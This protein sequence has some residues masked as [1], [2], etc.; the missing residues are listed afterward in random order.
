MRRV[1]CLRLGHSAS[2]YSNLFSFSEIPPSIPDVR[3][4]DYSKPASFFKE[5]ITPI[6]RRLL[7]V[8]VAEP[9]TICDF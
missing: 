5:V 9:F 3:L 8:T 4:Q 1:I 6:F 7:S 2:L